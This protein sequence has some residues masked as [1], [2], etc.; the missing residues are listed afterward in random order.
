MIEYAE[1][2]NDCKKHPFY[3]LARDSSINNIKL[4]ATELDVKEPE[5]S[6]LYKKLLIL[7]ILYP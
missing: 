7:K 4:N 2:Y 6:K 5:T 3:W 1:E